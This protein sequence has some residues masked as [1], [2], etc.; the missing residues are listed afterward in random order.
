MLKYLDFIALI[1]AVFVAIFLIVSI[2]IKNIWYNI[3]LTTLLTLVICMVISKIKSRFSNKMSFNKF[4]KYSIIQGNSFLLD[5]INRFF[6]T[7]YTVTDNYMQIKNNEII[8]ASVKYGN[9]GNDEIIKYYKIAKEKKQ[10]KFYLVCLKLDRNVTLV[11]NNLDISF[12]YIPLRLIFKIAKKTNLLPTVTKPES[13]KRSITLKIFN[14]IFSP[15]N[16]KRFL[17]VGLLLLALSLFIPF[18]FYYR[19]LGGI[20]L[21]L[22]LICL[23]NKNHHLDYGRYGVFNEF[24]NRRKKSLTQT[25]NIDANTTDNDNDGKS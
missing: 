3:A 6:R 23:I 7:E 13:K 18:K 5:L 20:N 1:V 14:V 2:F 12:T 9:I 16:A 25:I 11:A 19:I 22:A 10:T 4:V 21:T 24:L 15:S 17:F 8:F